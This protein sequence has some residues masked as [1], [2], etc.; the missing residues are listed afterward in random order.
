MSKPRLALCRHL[1]NLLAG[2]WTSSND[3]L[4]VLGDVQL[5]ESLLEEQSKVY[6]IDGVD[7]NEPATQKRK[8]KQY[9]NGE[10]VS[11]T[12]EGDRLYCF[13]SKNSF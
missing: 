13:G 4:S 7:E 6:K 9:V 5:D 10:E 12:H 1:R 8:R 2:A 11:A 3:V